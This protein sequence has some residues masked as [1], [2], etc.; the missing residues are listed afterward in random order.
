VLWLGG[1]RACCV[2]NFRSGGL[3]HD[4]RAASRRSR[5]LRGKSVPPAR[6]KPKPVLNTGATPSRLRRG[7]ASGTV[8]D[9]RGCGW[10]RDEPRYRDPM[11]PAEA[12]TLRLEKVPLPSAWSNAQNI[13]R[14]FSIDAPM[15]VLRQPVAGIVLDDP[16][17]P[18][19]TCPRARRA[20]CR[21]TSD[22]CA[23]Q[24]TFST[25]ITS[26]LLRSRGQFNELQ[27]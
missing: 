4:W 3:T 21:R 8:G 14:Q 22:L 20:T 16:P 26:H 19:S 18:G 17:T 6:P 25:S 13:A 23:R 7:Q 11:S 24:Q 2:C 9:R 10:Y 12:A 5:S 27:T 15:E 1:I